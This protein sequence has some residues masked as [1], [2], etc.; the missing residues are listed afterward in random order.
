VTVDDADQLRDAQVTWLRGVDE[1]VEVVQGCA[2]QVD[3]S[4]AKRTI[5]HGEVIIGLNSL[6]WTIVKKGILV[7]SSVISA[8]R[9]GIVGTSEE[10]YMPRNL[11][12]FAN[13]RE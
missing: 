1:L 3:L 13:Y 11:D 4:E 9:E 12:E 6:A 7:P 10:P 2:P 8:I 5:E